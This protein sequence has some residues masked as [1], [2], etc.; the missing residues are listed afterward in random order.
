MCYNFG[1][2]D[3]KNFIF[4]QKSYVFETFLSEMS[5]WFFNYFNAVM[6]RLTG[7]RNIL[8]LVLIQWGFMGRWYRTCHS[9]PYHTTHL[10]VKGYLPHGKVIWVQS[11]CILSSVYCGINRN[12]CLWKQRRNTSLYFAWQETRI[13]TMPLISLRVRPTSNITSIF[14]QGS[15][16]LIVKEN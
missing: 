9:K 6:H 4:L 14:L 3:W 12:S 13:S 15:C 16:Q 2:F 1:V 11:Q 8:Y 5:N 7:D 10:P